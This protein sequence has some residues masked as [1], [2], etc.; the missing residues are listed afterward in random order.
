MQAPERPGDVLRSAV[1]PARA[2]RL[3][4]WE[5]D[6]ALRHGLRE[7]VDWFARQRTRPKIAAG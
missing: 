7:T 6:V 5:P 4:G 2:A 3:W 1:S